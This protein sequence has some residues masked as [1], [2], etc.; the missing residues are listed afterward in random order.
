MTN[1]NASEPSIA[2]RTA[3]GNTSESAMS[4]VSSHTSLPARETASTS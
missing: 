2:R 1:T 4:S 3:S